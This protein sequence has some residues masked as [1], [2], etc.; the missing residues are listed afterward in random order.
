MTDDETIQDM[1]QAFAKIPLSATR[2]R[3]LPIEVNQFIAV[4]ER[5]RPTLVFE[6]EP[7]AFLRALES[8]AGRQ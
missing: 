5:V 3:E 1:N 8:V 4:S 6:A 2:I 7:A